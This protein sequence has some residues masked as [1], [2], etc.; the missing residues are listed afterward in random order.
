MK[1]ISAFTSLS[2][3]QLRER[4]AEFKKELLKLNSQVAS[5]ANVQNP[6]KLKQIKKNIA[7]ALTLLNKKEVKQE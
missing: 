5:G 3:E 2:E 7:R 1:R 6:G 4:L